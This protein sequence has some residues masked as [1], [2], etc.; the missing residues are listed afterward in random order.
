MDLTHSAA[1]FDLIAETTPAVVSP[2]LIL[3][4]KGSFLAAL[5]IIAVAIAVRSML[6]KRDQELEPEAAP[7]PPQPWAPPSFPPLPPVAEL[8]PSPY[9]PPLAPGMTQ[10]ELMTAVQT[11]AVMEESPVATPGVKTRHFHPL[12]LAA[13]GFF[14]LFFFAQAVA[15]AKMPTGGEVKYT[16]AALIAALVFQAGMAGGVLAIM[17]ARVRPVA[18]L[19]L[20]WPK[21]PWALLIG[22]A[23]VFT[24]WGILFGVQAAGYMKW[25]QSLGGTAQDTVELLKTSHDPVVLG[26]MA[27]IA[28]IVAPVCEEVIFRGYIYPVTKKFGGKWAAAVF[29]ALVFGA[30]HGNLPAL[31]PLFLLALGLIWLYEKTGSLW[32]PIAVHLCFNGATVLIQAL[33]RYLDLKVDPGL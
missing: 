23:G 29:T 1:V 30:A 26:L 33:V 25:A 2:E 24:M 13:V 7:L 10:A 16:P 15:Q 5:V 12:D 20:R 21:W 3:V 11:E 4:F 28:V 27:F 6:A 8:N 14:F 31:L 18:L 19:G 32:A 22:P 17:F 9:T